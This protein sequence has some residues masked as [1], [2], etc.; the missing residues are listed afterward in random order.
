MPIVRF[1]IWLFAILLSAIPLVA[2][3]AVRPSGLPNLLVAQSYTGYF[4]ELLFMCIA[5]GAV[6]IAESIELLIDL[7]KATEVGKLIVTALCLVSLLLIVVLG[8]I[9]YGIYIGGA[10]GGAN[11][12]VVDDVYAVFAILGSAVLGALFLKGTSKNA[13]PRF[14]RLE[15]C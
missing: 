2:A 3:V 14:D 12:V 5:I 8:G 10:R 11:S 9:W 15:S 13:I 7:D 6:A 4:G 1:V